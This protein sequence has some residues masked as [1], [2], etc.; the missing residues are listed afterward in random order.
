MKRAIEAAA[1]KLKEQQLQV[2][3]K[4]TPKLV[5]STGTVFR[6][7]VANPCRDERVECA[8]WAASG[9]CEDNSAYMLISCAFSC[10]MCSEGKPHELRSK[11]ER[12]SFS[13]T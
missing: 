9:E 12:K 3:D 13:A 5:N 6:Y 1:A 7:V 11:A 10:T 4:P 8:G 2:G